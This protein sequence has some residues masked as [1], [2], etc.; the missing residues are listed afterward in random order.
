MMLG[1]HSAAL[2]QAL[3]AF[4]TPAAGAVKRQPM[5]AGL[6]PGFQSGA[7]LGTRVGAGDVGDEQPA[8]G[9]P[10]L[11][12]GEVVGD[13]S[14]NLSLGQ[15]REEPKA[16]IVVVVTGAGAGR[17][18]AG[19]DMSA[20]VDDVGHVMPLSRSMPDAI[21]ERAAASITPPA[22]FYR[23][24]LQRLPSMCIHERASAG[25]GAA[26]TVRV[27]DHV[28]CRADSSGGRRTP[29]RTRLAKVGPR[30]AP[31]IATAAWAAKYCT[32]DPQS[33]RTC[34]LRP[35]PCRSERR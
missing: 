9:Q 6:E 30:R 7:L 12:V 20:V 10:F 19:N 22:P 34:P 2:R 11:H 33:P 24:E 28:R 5:A 29:L 15:Q 26:L 27:A 31:S 16:G 32:A 14:R 23:Q 8:H 4:G 25:S 17:K 18:A 1:F 3:D 35:C 21:G 13:G